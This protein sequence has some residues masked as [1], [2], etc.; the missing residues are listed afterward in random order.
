MLDPMNESVSRLATLEKHT[1]RL[2]RRIALLELVDQRFTWYRVA[3]FAG[4]GLLAWAGFSL[5]G[6]IWGWVLL[7]IGAAFFLELVRQR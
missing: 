6:G 3:A 1:H 5:L 2:E 7:G 4:G